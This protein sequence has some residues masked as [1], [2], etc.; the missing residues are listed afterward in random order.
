MR[1]DKYISESTSYSR[2]EIKELFK[3]G[4]VTVDG[5]AQKDSGIQIKPGESHIEIDGIKVEYKPFVYLMLNKPAG[6][7]SA[8]EDNF[9]NTVIELIPGEYLHYEPFPVGRL[10]K[11]TE[12]LLL[13][14]NDGDLAHKLLSPKKKVPKIYHAVAEKQVDE[15]AVKAFQKGIYLKE[16]D[17]TTLPGSLKVIEEGEHP[18]CEVI[19]YEGK[20]HQVKRMFEKVNNKVLYLKRVEFAGIKLDENL[21][22]GQVRELTEKEE[23][24]IKGQDK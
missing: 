16:E 4:R 7:I 6:Y 10:D 5:V 21:N 18:L 20:F 2:K 14:T 22:P 24:L 15:K 19:I 1:A 23:M 11:D 8:T 9:Q 13:L 17:F 12:G 3:K